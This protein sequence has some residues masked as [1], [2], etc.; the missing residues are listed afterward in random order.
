MVILTHDLSH[1]SNKFNN[2][3]ARPAYMNASTDAGPARVRHTRE[4][5]SFGSATC[6]RGRR[7]TSTT[8]LISRESMESSTNYRIF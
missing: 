7:T 8:T 5:S 2:D 1:W 6:R 4:E 3:P